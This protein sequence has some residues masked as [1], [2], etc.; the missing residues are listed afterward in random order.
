[1]LPSAATYA[2]SGFCGWIRI[3]P[4]RPAFGRPT[5]CHVLPASVDLYTPSPNET[6]PRGH[7][8]PVPTNTTL[9]LDSETSMAPI[10]PTP[11]CPSVSGIHCAPPSVDLNTPPAAPI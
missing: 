11:I 2:M 7:A 3:L 1:M 6:L 9:G 10:V 5:C 4:M 8:D